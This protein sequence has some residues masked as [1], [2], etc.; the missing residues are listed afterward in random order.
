MAEKPSIA[1]SI[2]SALSGGHVRSFFLLS[3]FFPPF[4]L[5]F[6]QISVWFPRNLGKKKRCLGFLIVKLCIF[7]LI[8]LMLPCQDSFFEFLLSVYGLSEAFSL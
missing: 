6:L 2:A 8:F 5:S 4:F 1:L 7:C 3:L